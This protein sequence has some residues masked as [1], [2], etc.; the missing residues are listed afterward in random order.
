MVK[1]RD[2]HRNGN[3]SGFPFPFP[4]FPGILGMRIKISTKAIFP[5]SSGIFGMRIKISTEASFSDLIERKG[6]TL[7]KAYHSHI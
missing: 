6:E 5:K 3:G 7:Y 2:G 1:T 4:L